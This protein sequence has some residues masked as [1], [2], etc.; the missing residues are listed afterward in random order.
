M[1]D[2]KGIM[3]AL[4]RNRKIA[5]LPL[6]SIF[7]RAKAA[8]AEIKDPIMTGGIEY[9]MVFRKPRTKGISDHI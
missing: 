4:R 6:K 8:P 9:S 2:G 7:A 5:F 3:I 1:I